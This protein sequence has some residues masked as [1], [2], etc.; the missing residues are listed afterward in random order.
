MNTAALPRRGAGAVRRWRAGLGSRPGSAGPP[1]SARSSPT[2]PV[3]APALAAERSAALERDALLERT[4]ARLREAFGALAG[5]AL[6]P[7]QRGVRRSSPRR[8]WPRARTAADGELA[9][10]QQAIE[11]IVGAAAG[12]ARRVQ[13][14][15][16]R[17]RARIAPAVRRTARSRSRPCGRPPSSCG[18][19]PPSWSPRCARRRCAAGGASCSCERVVEAAGMTEHCR[20]HQQVAATERRDGLVRPDLVVQPRRRQ[21]RRGRREG[22]RSPATWR[23]WRRA[24]RRPGTPG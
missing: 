8:G 9:Q 7:Q 1:N 12:V 19:R 21:E 15:L 2:P 5:E 23:R 11:G 24:T 6:S 17:G 3:C 13:H 18:P 10:R 22:R 16:P 20:L 14:Q 4:D